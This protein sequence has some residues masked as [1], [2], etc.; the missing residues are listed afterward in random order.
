MLAWCTHGRLMN[1]LDPTITTTT[2]TTITVLY[3]QGQ[4]AGT[5]LCC[6]GYRFLW[7]VEFIGIACVECGDARLTSRGH[8]YQDRSQDPR[9]PPTTTGNYGGINKHWPSLTH[10]YTDFNTDTG[11]G[12]PDYHIVNDVVYLKNPNISASLASQFDKSKHEMLIFLN[13]ILQ[14]STAKL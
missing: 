5:V 3:L 13:K 1:S 2:T 9:H 12:W 14:S 8:W 11:C 7:L 6:A 4:N 10:I